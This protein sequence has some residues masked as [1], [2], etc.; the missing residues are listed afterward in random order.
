MCPAAACTQPRHAHSS[1]CQLPN[2][3][4]AHRALFAVSVSIYHPTS[5]RL[6]VTT[7]STSS[8]KF[9]DCR[10]HQIS[11]SQCHHRQHK[12][13]KCRVDTVNTRN[14]SVGW[15]CPHKKIFWPSAAPKIYVNS[16]NGLN[17][18]ISATRKAEAA[19]FGPQWPHRSGFGP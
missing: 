18:A 10:Q 4:P 16:K 11:R 17:I 9:C 3:L 15:P 8:R 7:I 13:L 12:P 1:A 2:Q 6:D 14:R 5:S 19:G